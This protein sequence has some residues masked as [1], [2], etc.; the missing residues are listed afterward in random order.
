MMKGKHE[1]LGGALYLITHLIGFFVI[2][3][4]FAEFK[5]CT[6]DLIGSKAK[7]NIQ[8]L[9]HEN[10]SLK[11]EIAIYKGMNK[12]IKGCDLDDDVFY[13]KGS[14]PKFYHLESNCPAL[15]LN[16]KKIKVKKLEQAIE[17]G[18]IE[19]SI[20]GYN[21]RNY[22]NRN[23]TSEIVYICTSG[24]SKRY[25]SDRYCSGLGRCTGEIEEVSVEDAEDMGRT[26]CHICY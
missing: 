5:E 25:H 16:S 13:S 22:N 18:M 20:C 6:I 9:K 2:F 23:K 15:A 4:L 19:C 8:N 12:D 14:N 1:I 21:E 7:K 24:T 17:E 11:T 10:D 3:F 26:P